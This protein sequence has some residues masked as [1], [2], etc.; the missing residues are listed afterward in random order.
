MVNWEEETGTFDF[1]FQEINNK[2]ATRDI[3]RPNE[4]FEERLRPKG[5]GG[6]LDSPLPVPPWN[7]RPYPLLKFKTMV[8]N[9][10]W[11]RT[12]TAVN[13]TRFHIV[14]LEGTGQE[15][16]GLLIYSG[17]DVAEIPRGTVQLAIL[18]RGFSVP[19]FTFDS[20]AQKA[21]KLPLA[22]VI[23]L[24]KVNGVHERRGLG[25]VS[26]ECFQNGSLPAPR[27]E[28]ILLG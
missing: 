12:T 9:L 21:L 24:V 13:Y 26:E 23:Y 14:D 19:P 16:V 18:G 1:G 25:F 6:L 27:Y 28:T 15:V 5:Y 3:W 17:T 2:G 10:H 4:T 20:P 22:Y 7:L 8:I 11:K